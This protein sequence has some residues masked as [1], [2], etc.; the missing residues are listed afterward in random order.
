[1]DITS[2][3]CEGLN[4]YNWNLYYFFLLCFLVCDFH[5]LWSVMRPYFTVITKCYPML[6]I[7]GVVAAI[8]A[9]QSGMAPIRNGNGRSGAVQR[10]C[11]RGCY[12][13]GAARDLDWIFAPLHW[14][15]GNSENPSA[16]LLS[17][18]A[19]LRHR[20]APPRAP[21]PPPRPGARC[22]S[23]RLFVPFFP[24]RLC[25]TVSLLELI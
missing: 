3:R 22:E 24:K 4:L 15:R 13:S 17:T 12:R 10:R 6:S 8:A 9:E 25:D 2:S 14:S 21:P 11:W 20:R 18:P 5:A 7:V 1:M 16:L 23:A 19:R